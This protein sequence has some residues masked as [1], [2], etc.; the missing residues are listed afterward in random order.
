MKLPKD[1]YVARLVV[2]DPDEIQFEMGDITA[3]AT[4]AIVN[5]ANAELAPGAGVCGAIHRAG[6]Q[7]I[8]D[9]CAAIRAKRGRLK[10]GD[11]VAT[12]GG[13]LKAKQVIHAVGPVWSGGDK[14]EPGQLAS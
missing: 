5:A 1:R 2:A 7:S 9:E 4:E 12:K 14:G 8:F 6:G 3:E 11:A 13:A 10:T